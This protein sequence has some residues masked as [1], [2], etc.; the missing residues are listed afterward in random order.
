MKRIQADIVVVS[1][2]TAGLPA[3]VT[4]AE[5]GASVI[6]LEKRG[7]TGGTGNRANMILG[8]QSRLQRE[9]GITLT[10]E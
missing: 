5:G 1:A 10:P 7:N 4:A 2:G 3:A 9:Q 8:I 6:V